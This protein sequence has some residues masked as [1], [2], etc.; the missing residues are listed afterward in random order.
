MQRPNIPAR[1]SESILL[2]GF[3]LALALSL[4]FNGFLLIK[5][6]HTRSIYE[7][8]MRNTT[9]HAGDDTDERVRL[10]AV[11]VPQAN[12]M[13]STTE[14]PPPNHPNSGQKPAEK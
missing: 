9:A 1:R 4:A 13:D 10:R 7:Y 6:S 3:G 11:D 12:P 2:Y 5:Q 8:E 14:A